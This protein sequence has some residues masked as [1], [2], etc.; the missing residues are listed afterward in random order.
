MQQNVT[1][2]RN[3]T[4]EI[5]IILNENNVN[6]WCVC[7]HSLTK[8]E[9]DMMNI[10]N[11][12]VDAT[13]CRNSYIRGGT[14][15]LSNTKLDMTEIPGIS[16]LS[17]EK[18]IEICAV[19]VNKFM[20]YVISVYRSPSGNFNI[21]LDILEQAISIIG[22]NKNVI[23][24]GD[25]NLHFGTE[26]DEVGTFLN[27]METYGLNQQ[28]FSKT[29]KNNC[30][31]N[32]FVNFGI[33]SSYSFSKDFNISDHNA[34]ILKFRPPHKVD[35][36]ANVKRKGRPVTESGKIK[37]YNIVEDI[38]WD[39]ISD[40]SIS[41]EDKVSLFLNKLVDAYESAFHEKTY[42]TT[43]SN[44]YNCSW[45]N[46]DLK[47]FRDRVNCANDLYKKYPTDVRLQERNRLKREYKKAIKLAKIEH[48]NNLINRAN[49]PTKAVWDIVGRY[50]NEPRKVNTSCNVSAR[51]FNIY[52]SNIAHNLTQK[53][54]TTQR[55][56]N[57]NLQY[58]FNLD[59]QGPGFSFREVSYMEVRDIIKNLK[60]K[61]TKDCYGLSTMLL[62]IVGNL[63][64]YPLTKLINMSITS[65]H[66][67]DMLKTA[68]VIPIYKNK[69]DRSDMGSYRP[70]SLLPAISKVY[71]RCMAVQI[72]EYFE[73]NNLFTDCQ[74]GFRK[75]HSTITGMVELV[76]TALEAFENLEH[77]GMI[78]C[79]LSKAFDCVS[80]R[81]LIHKLRRY[82]FS[83]DGIEFISS[84]LSNR[85]QR[86]VVGGGSSEYLELT[87]G[88]PQ[89][90][91]LGPLLFLIFINDLPESISSVNFILF[92]DDTTMTIRAE[93]TEELVGGM[94]EA[95]LRAKDWF[96]N[97]ELVLNEEKTNLMAF[98]LR[99]CNMGELMTCSEVKF[100]GIHLDPTLKWNTHIDNLCKKLSKN[101]F[102]LR[103]LAYCV[104][105]DI[106]C[107]VYFSL[108]H[109]LL[110]YSV[111]VWGHAAER[112][113][114]FALQRRAIRIIAGL[115]YRDDC[116][117]SFK[118]LK[119]LTFPCI[120]ILENLLYAKKNLAKY[121]SNNDF[122]H[123]ET[124]NREDLTT[125]YFRLR[126]CQ[127]GPN[128]LAIKYFNK[129]PKKTRQLP[130]NQF[131]NR[132]KEFLISEAFYDVD[133]FLNYTFTSDL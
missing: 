90:S 49:N 60:N 92:A 93:E 44:T 4:N 102:L 22:A 68:L 91:I 116:S 37:F 56:N 120:F 87:V 115:N 75:G 86:V 70:I 77:A 76:T 20:F 118:N 82:N 73:S 130:L 24:A 7:E 88:V 131:K 99:G 103:N 80:H 112:G 128:F 105:Q 114:V 72:L 19:L 89:G 121:N 96:N 25:F 95:Q 108:C 1:S 61:S 51:D 83:T 97:N 106:L 27:V 125:P 62:K 43:K 30:L 113:R 17:I 53:S 26:K 50:R 58:N 54:E 101:I 29:R 133:S 34:Q 111:L 12:K 47:E 84:Y 55:V 123:Y 107:T 117:D 124:R 127:N 94:R 16:K 129:I 31:D 41:L 13:F 10:N 122:H 74:H 78:F 2:I 85:K 66:F 109:S 23:L 110:S 36:T 45:F 21:F 52:F 59:K 35:E 11:Y 65:G 79:D 67:P 40:V 18:Q 46:Q 28:I 98:S 9:M 71:E 57:L 63:I 6:I 69:G 81:I 14:A 15:I 33:D 32:I 5:E 38:S 3:K 64:V 8:D 119:I 104:S 100:L 132:I 48:N 42:L 126:K 39:F